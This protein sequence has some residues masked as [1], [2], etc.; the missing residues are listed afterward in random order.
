MTTPDSTKDQAAPD[1]ASHAPAGSEAEGAAWNSP[2]ARAQLTARVRNILF[3]PRT[4]WQRIDQEPASIAGIYSRHVLPLAAIPPIATLIG[5]LVFGVSVLG[6]TYRPSVASALTSAVVQYGLTLAGIFVLGLVINWLAPK[7]GGAA[8]KVRAFK[9]AAYSATAAW[10]VGVFN[11]LPALSVLTVLGLYS[12]Y[13]LYLGLPLLMKAP[14]E[15][16]LAYT[17]VVVLVMV[18][19]GLLIGSLT[20]A[21]TR[22]F[23]SDNAIGSAAIADMVESLGEGDETVNSADIAGLA[24]SMAAGDQAGAILQNPMGSQSAAI[25]PKRLASLLPQNLAGL[26]VTETQNASVG[27][28][29]GS[30]AE[31]RYGSGDRTVSVEMVDMAPIGGIS[32][33]ASSLSVQ[34]DRKTATGY[35]RL[36]QVNGRMTG[37]KWDSVS[38]RS[39]YNILVGN[40]VMVSAEGRGVE[41]DVLKAAINDLDLDAIEAAVARK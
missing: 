33:M 5:S 3:T 18:I 31:A 7:F 30:S 13:L 27:G 14:K 15:K 16:A 39:E 23:A 40:R 38:K 2:E 4:E 34:R 35:E 6:M 37:E 24:E 21:L 17:G 36:G 25:D 10:V 28:G 41:I 32:A 19:G 9:V 29:L 8:D 12:L 26:P 22:P 1:A 11:I 20:A